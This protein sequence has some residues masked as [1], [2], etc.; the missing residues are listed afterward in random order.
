MRVPRGFWMTYLKLRDVLLVRSYLKSSEDTRKDKLKLEDAAI[1]LRK[2]AHVIYR[3]YFS[4][5]NRKFSDDFFFN[6]FLIFAQN[7]GCG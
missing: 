6:I 3:F 5:E 2:H 4:C 7:I 1:T